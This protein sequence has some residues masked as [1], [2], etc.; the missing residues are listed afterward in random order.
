MNHY[1]FCEHSNLIKSLGEAGEVEGE[2]EA[3]LLEH[4]VDF[5]DFSKEIIDSLPQL[6]WSIPKVINPNIYDYIPLTYPARP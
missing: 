5:A 1:P 2:S 3:I 4:N 6:P